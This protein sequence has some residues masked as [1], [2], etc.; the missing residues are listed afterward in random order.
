MTALLIL[1]SNGA[2]AAEW[3]AAPSARLGAEFV[4]N[5]LLVPKNATTYTDSTGDG[6]ADLSADIA[7]HAEHYDI[8]VDPRVFFSR[9]LHRSVFDH[10]DQ[11]LSVGGNLRSERSTWQGSVNAVR[12]TALTSEV[13]VTG[14]T[15][16]NRRRE[17]LSLSAGPSYQLTERLS[18]TGTAGW[19][20]NHYENADHTGLLDYRYTSGELAGN[21]S[22]TERST[23]GLDA[24]FGS[25]SSES[26]D[27][28]TSYA[29]QA[30]YTDRLT[31]LWTLNLSGGPSRGEFGGGAHS[32]GA[33][34][35]AALTHKG[36]LYDF[37]A[38]ISR[39]VTPTGRGVLTKSDQAELN[40]SGSITERLSLVSSLFYSHN[41]DY[42]SANGAS[43][44]VFS[45]HY[46]S[47]QES[48][49]WKLSPSWAVD[50]TAQSQ[51]Q[52]TVVP[53]EH[54]ENASAYRIG[55]GIT[56]TGRPRR[57]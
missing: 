18:L 4:D 3:N 9:Y 29:L 40:V 8:T 36:E 44:N 15:D 57:L 48:L 45:L 46:F 1:G 27:H 51:H 53:P 37:T 38:R 32:S 21:Y 50:L 30:A 12:D 23:A 11:F 42:F 47:V 20:A 14:I 10:D 39:T 7:K 33:V 26:G 34:Y 55:L 22:L 54:G 43:G 31:E 16:T 2:R 19:L 24:I 17:N 25:L 56:W 52:A 13:G 6:T 28:S 41:R 35:S 5:P 49:K